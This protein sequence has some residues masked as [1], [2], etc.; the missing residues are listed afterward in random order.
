MYS[1]TQ[2]FVSEYNFPSRRCGWNLG[3][4]LFLIVACIAS[5]CTLNNFI[6]KFILIKNL[7]EMI[8]NKIM[9][10]IKSNIFIYKN[11]IHTDQF[12]IFPVDS[13]PHSREPD[14]Y[15]PIVFFIRKLFDKIVTHVR[16]RYYVDLLHNGNNK[17][18]LLFINNYIVK[19]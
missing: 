8:V 2:K 4:K 16:N 11:Q 17:C 13:I 6:H 3:A 1:A 5:F 9:I 10:Y 14:S 12:W 7:I 19:R 18:I 15:F